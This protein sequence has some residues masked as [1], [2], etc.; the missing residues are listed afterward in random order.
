MSLM[1]GLINSWSGSFGEFFFNFVET[2]LCDVDRI[3]LECSR[4]GW[5]VILLL[6]SGKM[7]CVF[8]DEGDM[9]QGD[10]VGRGILRCNPFEKVGNSLGS[11]CNNIFVL[12]SMH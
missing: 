10:L 9:L 1:C 5:R 6:Q 4:C 11:L 8:D 7:Y 2:S 3:I 12:A